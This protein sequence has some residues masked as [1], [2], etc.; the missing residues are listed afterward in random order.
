MAAIEGLQK[1]G[2]TGEVLSLFGDIIIA[3]DI[4]GR[5]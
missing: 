3:T 2:R 1:L 5:F 4:D